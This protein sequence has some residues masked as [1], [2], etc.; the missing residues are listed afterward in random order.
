[1]NMPSGAA[2]LPNMEFAPN[3]AANW[4][5]Q[6]GGLS[7]GGCNGS[8]AFICAMANNLAA[9]ALAPNA[10]TATTPYEWTWEISVLDSTAGGAASVFAGAHGVKISY[11]DINGHLVSSDFSFSNAPPPHESTT[12]PEPITS[13]LVGMGLVSLFFLRRRVRG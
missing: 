7:N 11:S 3:G 6:S 9:Q 12:V 4:T 5:P 13:G 8:G 2:L 10:S 1:M